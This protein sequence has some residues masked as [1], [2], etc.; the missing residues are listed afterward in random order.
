MDAMK[1]GNGLG[2]ARKQPMSPAKVLALGFFLLIAAGTAL[3]V[4]PIAHQ[5]GQSVSLLEA[6]FTATS[7]TCVT[8][9]TLVDTY[10]TFSLFGQLVI[11]ALIQVGGLGFMLFAT[12]TLVA[13]GRRISLRNRMLL[14][15]TM[16]MP[17]LS[18]GVR[19]TIRFM[20][21]AFSIELLGA[22][23]LALRFIPLYGFGRGMYF[24]VFH[25]ISA[26][27]N[28]GFDLFGQAG[29]L[30]GFRGDPLVLMTISSL[31]ILGGLG[32]TVIADVSDHRRG[33]RRLSLHSKIVLV[34]NG[35][36]LLTGFAFFAAMEW[37]NMG[38]LAR[39]EAGGGEKLLNAWFQSVTTRTAGFFSLDQA[40][41][42]DASKLV[43]TVLMFIG[44][45]PASTGGGVKTSTFF[46]VLLILASI[47]AG[48]EDTNAFSRRLS[49]AIGRT[50]QSILFIHLSLIVL[51]GI[52]L[53]VIERG[54]GIN[55]IDLLFEEAS[56]LGTVGLSAAGTA[57]FR[58]PSKLMFILFMYFGRVGPMTMMLSF[59]RTKPSGGDAIR[60]PQEEIIVG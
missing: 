8:G 9:L 32:F 3:L 59:S 20:L 48:R 23:L 42:S 38:T 2:R 13:L 7:A 44:A 51:G 55:L 33:P 22:A 41:M 27:C 28:A 29:S 47:V 35:L 16:S 45:S 56:A 50:A 43:S 54:A 5:A 4:L 17:G 24:G 49:S 52:F 36:L 1:Q 58:L 40:A 12:M 60:Y 15:E 10:S 31:I 18:G 34:M 26:F 46:V 11:I 6:L 39:P 37:N 57:G 19:T 25:A 21:I 30:Q 53:A 14:R